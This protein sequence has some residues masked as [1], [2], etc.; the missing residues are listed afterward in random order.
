[1]EA[2][3]APV[4]EHGLFCCWRLEE[5]DGKPTKVPYNPQTGQ[6]AQSNNPASFASLTVA[7]MAAGGY[8]GLGVG[9]FNDL[10]A[11]DLDHC[12]T[13]DGV[14]AWAKDIVET[15]GSYTE[16][17]PSGTGLRILFPVAQPFQYDT[18]RY[19]INRRLDRNAGTGIEI[20]VAGATRKYVT[21]TGDVFPVPF[22]TPWE[23]RSK[24]VRQVLEKYMVR[25]QTKQ[26]LP[27]TSHVPQVSAPAALDDFAVIQRAQQSR[28]GTAFSR[29]WAGD[30]SG[31]NSH[32]EAD[33]ALLNHLAFWTGRNPEQMDRLFRQSGLMREKWDRRQSGSTYGALTIQHACDR[34]REVYAPGKAQ[35]EGTDHYPAGQKQEVPNT[36][37]PPDFSD[38]GNAEVF[39]RLHK[40]ELIFTDALGW[41]WWNGKNWERSDH[42][43]VALATSLSRKML[44]EANKENAASLQKEAEAKAKFDESGNEAD[45]PLLEEAKSAAAMAKAYLKHAKATREL[46]RIK[47]MIELSKPELVVPA[48][49]LD[50]KASELNTPAGIVDLNTGTIRPHDRRAYCTK[51]TAAAPGQQGAQMWADFLAA[52]TQ[53]DINLQIFLQTVC[54]MALFGKVYHEGIIMA[55][56]GGRNGKST[57][58]N[59]VGA[60]LGDYA[61]SIAVDTLTVNRN[62]NQGASLATLRGKRLVITGELEEHQRLSIAMLKRL[63]ST[64]TLRIEE[65]YRAPE[66]IVPSHSIVL[67]T[68][69]LPRV[70]STDGGTWRRLVV[71]PFQATISASGVIANYGEV[72]AKEAGPAILQWCIEGAVLFARNRFRLELPEA[73]EEATAEYRER[74]DWLTNFLTERCRRGPNYRAGAAE[75]YAGYKD[76]AA[77]SGEYVRRLNDFNT[78]MEC[79]GYHQIRPGNRKTWEGVELDHAV[80]FA[81]Y[82]QG[83]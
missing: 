77:A 27:Q 64:D 46:R 18:E 67:F 23:D 47:N 21:V 63:A 14:A 79:A 29:L 65:K 72:L 11:I 62:G 73:V 31:Y 19:Y 15:M 17:S 26:P 6:R 40:D 4:R 52:V 80:R 9:I 25:E 60:V 2:L 35:G 42:K 49:Q 37:R 41:L 39:S 61:G 32:S 66:D 20:Y 68:N 78:A 59:A 56:G 70:G 74:E 81:Q 5:R 16:I 44:R 54:G 10:A 24:Q 28:N 71:V 53:G 34:C 33:M 7:T 1:M 55:Y 22:A 51:I 36:A 8:S 48:A 50:A 45:K 82:S 38:A 69:H 76:W 12:L 3:P 43:A 58:F 75:L 13:S 57:L 83:Y 30:W